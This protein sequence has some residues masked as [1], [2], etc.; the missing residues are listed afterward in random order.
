MTHPRVRGPSIRGAGGKRRT[1]A[2]SPLR[3]GW[4]GSFDGRPGGQI[5]AVG[6]RWIHLA[7]GALRL[8]RRRGVAATGVGRR[9]A[10][11]RNSSR[12]ELQ[13]GLR[14]QVVSPPPAASAVRL[15]QGARPRHGRG[16]RRSRPVGPSSAPGDGLVQTRVIEAGGRVGAVLLEQGVDLGLGGQVGGMVAHAEREPAPATP[17][18]RQTSPAF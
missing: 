6:R 8:G 7:G 1:R 4:S 3:S 15:R 13:Q 16:G 17:A 10:F 9:T 5:E 11:G 12:R 14:C 2:A 18:P